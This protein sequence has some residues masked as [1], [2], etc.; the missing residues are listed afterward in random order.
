[1]IEK[2]I[3]MI[4]IVCVLLLNALRVETDAVRIVVREI[5]MV[6]VQTAC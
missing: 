5:M 1:M 2:V 4:P 3:M 6:K